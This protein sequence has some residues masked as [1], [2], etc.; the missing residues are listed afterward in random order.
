[1]EF[2]TTS[3][4]F[5]LYKFKHWQR[6]IMDSTAFMICLTILLEMASLKNWQCVNMRPVSKHM[7]V[8]LILSHNQPPKCV[9]KGLIY[10]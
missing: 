5:S 10:F 9:L 2:T 8:K 1:M 3:I 6:L 4:H 7:Y